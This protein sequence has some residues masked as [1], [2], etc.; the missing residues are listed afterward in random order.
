MILLLGG[1]FT[2]FCFDL[3]FEGEAPKAAHEFSRSYFND[4]RTFQQEVDKLADQAEAM[5]RKV[6]LPVLR[7]QMART[8]YAFKRIEFFFD[9]WNPHYNHFY[10]GGRPLPKFDEEILSALVEPMGLQALE[11]L[12]FNEEAAAHISLIARRAGELKKSVDLIIRGHLD[13]EFTDRQLIEALRSGV[14]RVFALG[15]TGFDTP[16]CG[17]AISEAKVSMEAME[18]A[19]LH[20]GKN[21]EPVA[22]R[23]FGKIRGLFREAKQLLTSDEDFD[24]FDRMAYLKQVINPLFGGLLDFQ[25]KNKIETEHYYNHALNFNARNLFDEDFLKTGFYAQFSFL[26]LDNPASVKLGKTLFYD[27]I[28]SKNMDMSCATCH[29]PGKAFTDGLPKSKG[30]R[31]GEFTTR[32][33]PTLIDAGYASRY[34]WDMRAYN[35]EQQVAHVVSDTLEFNISFD[36]IAQRLYRSDTYVAM[37]ESIYGPVAKETIY[38]RSISNAIAA[39]VNSLK[40]FDS[41]FDKFVRNEISSYPEEAVRGFNLFMGKAACGT[42]H[43]APVFN[44][45]VPPFYAETE[46]E[47]LGVTTGLDTLDPGKDSDPGR[48]ENGLEKDAY[49]HFKNS[50]KTVTVRNAALTAP[51]MHNGL[52]DTLEEVLEFYDRG[53]GAGMG[54]NV[55]NQSLPDTPLNLSEREKADII[56]FLHTLTDTTGLTRVDI[57]LPAFEGHPEWRQESRE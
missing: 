57:E 49:P 7:A 18:K 20:F 5:H 15:L 54:L 41:E 42:C 55:E 40:S 33:S 17:Q 39:Y 53:G 3:T 2:A 50:F 22:K 31:S 24:S 30:N 45:V 8:R 43:F 6:D 23:E 21:L 16:G 34:F 12:I 51:Y 36:E 52:F 13:D 35:L 11:E 46:S 32:N 29:D 10:L 4:F 25:R 28:L 47:V 1:L 38:Q 9:Y 48:M 56:A 44:G 14:V 37:F 26:P 19:F 27:P